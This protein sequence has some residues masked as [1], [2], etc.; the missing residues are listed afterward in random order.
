MPFPGASTPAALASGSILAAMGAGAQ[1]APCVLGG[2]GDAVP[3]SGIGSS[4]P[5][6]GP[7]LPDV[8]EFSGASCKTFNSGGG[9]VSSGLATPAGVSHN[10]VQ[11]SGCSGPAG[12]CTTFNSGGVVQ[13]TGLATPAVVSHSSVLSSGSSGAGESCTTFTS[14]GVVLPSARVGDGTPSV[15]SSCAVQSARHSGP[16]SANTTIGVG[17]KRRPRGPSAPDER[18]VV[19]DR[20]PPLETAIR[21]FADRGTEV[22]VNPVLGA[23][24]DSLAEAYEFYNLYSWEVGFG[25]HYGKRRKMSMGRSVCKRLCAAAL[26]NQKRRRARQRGAIAPPCLGCT[27]QMM[28]GGMYLK[29]A[30]PTTMKC[31]GLVLRS[32]IGH[33]TSTLTHTQEIS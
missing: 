30:P 26:A 11:A 28:V 33:H 23:I 12:L 3:D 15:V 20:V 17:W 32:C 18:A 10:S 22:V 7:V 21:G 6:V 16:A 9:D 1:E 13:P 14:Q 5:A 31:Y 4:D 8:P 25:I 27:E 24:F 2:G 29:I 19:A